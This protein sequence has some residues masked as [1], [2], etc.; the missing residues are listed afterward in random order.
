MTKPKKSKTVEQTFSEDILNRARKVADTY[1][2]VIEP[3]QH[4]IGYSGSSIEM[5]CVLSEGKTRSDCVEAQ[6]RAMVMSVAVILEDAKL[7]PKPM[8]RKV[9]DDEGK[10][11]G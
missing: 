2:I 7:P 6:Y 11:E 10:C 1:S 5:P 3:S 4:S 9:A 8:V